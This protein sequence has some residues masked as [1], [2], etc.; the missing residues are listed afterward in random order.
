MQSVAHEELASRPSQAERRPGSEAPAPMR[1]LR[2]LAR[3]WTPPVL[4]RTAKRLR[5]G[6]IG[7]GRGR[8]YRVGSVTLVL[9]ADHALPDYRARWPLYDEPLHFLAEA[10][11]EVRPGF[12]AI[13]IGAN[14]GDSA[15]AMG[16]EGSTSVPVPV[17]CIEGDPAYL[18]YLDRNAHSLGPQVEVE[19]CFVGS[20]QGSLGVGLLQRHDGTTSAVRGLESIASRIEP[21]DPDPASGIPVRR[22]EQIL[23]RHPLFDGAELIKLDTD[24][25]DFSILLAH[26]EL[27]ARTRP[28]LFFEYLVESTRDAD[29]ARACLKMLASIGYV[30]FLVFDN[31]GNPLL[32][33]QDVSSMRDLDRY[34][35]SN[36]AFGQVVYYLDLCAAVD[37]DQKVLDLVTHRMA[38]L[39]ARKGHRRSAP[40]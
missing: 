30:D 3:D 21:A 32:R 23:A 17:L 13:D 20:A 16:K 18:Q 1:S 10:L 40:S 22:L 38:T 36:L 9:P 14:V 29:L 2:D 37:A 33:T 6:A 15:A 35:L 26:K 19:S 31:F 7:G 24:G 11:R 5:R 4:I 25:F 8:T 12:R 34:L 39:A 27:L 28:V